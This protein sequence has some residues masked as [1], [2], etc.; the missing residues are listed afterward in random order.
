MEFE[1][2]RNLYFKYFNIG[3]FNLKFEDRFKLIGLICFM[4]QQL[5]K[6]N[7]SITYLK[8]IKSIDKE[9]FLPTNMHDALALLCED[10]AYYCEDIPSFNV[11]P[12]EI[13]PTIRE[14]FKKWMPF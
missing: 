7:S 13:L 10:F 2:K 14:M 12:K 6:K 1:E 9:N 8:L 11:E 4:Y 3:Y 5:T